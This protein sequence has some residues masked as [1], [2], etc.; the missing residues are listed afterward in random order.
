MALIVHRRHVLHTPANTA[1]QTDFRSRARVAS[2]KLPFMKLQ[3]RADSRVRGLKGLQEGSTS[4]QCSGLVEL[5]END[6][7]LTQHFVFR[8]LSLAIRIV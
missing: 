4:A 3:L 8:V 2:T 5:M 7:F 6:R 1:K